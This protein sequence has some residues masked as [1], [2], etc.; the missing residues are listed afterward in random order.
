[1]SSRA[2]FLLDVNNADFVILLDNFFLQEQADH[3]RRASREGPGR[4]Y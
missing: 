2:G 4:R 1:M 3:D